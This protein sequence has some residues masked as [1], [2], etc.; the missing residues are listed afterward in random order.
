MWPSL[1]E[2]HESERNERVWKVVEKERRIGK[3]EGP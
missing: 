1:D 2:I 3:S